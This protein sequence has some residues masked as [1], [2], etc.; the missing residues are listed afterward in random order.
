MNRIRMAGL[1]WSLAGTLSLAV[2]AET[3]LDGV[4]RTALKASPDVKSAT[5]RLAA[6]RAAV[7]EAESAYYPQLG[8]AGNWMRTD[9][10]PQ[11]FFMSLNQRR[12]S[13]QKDFNHPEDTENLRGSVVAQW[14]VFDSGRREADR[15]T[16]RM[17]AQASRDALDAVR[18]SL[19]YEITRAYYGVLEARDVIAVQEDMVKSVS[20]SLRVAKE[21]I[22]AGSAM[23]TDGLN[24]DVQLA[25]ANEGLIRARHGLQLAVVALNTAVG[26]PVLEE[27]GVA[28]LTGQPDTTDPDPLA[29]TA[30]E[31]RPEWRAM[32]AQVEATRAMTT[33]ARHE[34]L[35]VVNAFGSLD[36]D[37]ETWSGPERSYL[38]GVTLEMNVFDGFR[39]RSGVARA[40]AGLA[41]AEAELDKVRN[42]LD[43]D[44]T[45]SRL[46]ERERVERREVVRKSVASAEESLRITRERYREGAAPI[47]ELM[48]AQTAYGAVRTRLVASHYDCLVAR[49]NVER[50]SGRLVETWSQKSE[51]GDTTGREQQ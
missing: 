17:G 44:L 3:T 40:A 43:L 34:Y 28:S 13:L 49:T 29:A 36:W 27:S 41:A 7:K 26:T 50:A 9:N 45:Q 48:A 31:S 51:V 22:Q 35:P 6:A 10:P 8:L 18:N 1:T 23:R 37:S 39:N 16:A 2:A 42:T 15:R 46:N 21:R 32:N 12:A 24:L 14:R 11:A 19:V 5:A 20:E 33:R 30:V 38:A 47:T 4:I 25:E